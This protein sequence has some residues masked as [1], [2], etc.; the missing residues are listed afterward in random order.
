[1]E[2]PNGSTADDDGRLGKHTAGRKPTHVASS[3]GGLDG[4]QAAALVHILQ[5]GAFSLVG[6]RLSGHVRF[7]DVVSERQ[8]SSGARQRGTH[9][10]TH[11]NAGEAPGGEAAPHHC[12]AAGALAQTNPRKITLFLRAGS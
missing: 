7:K 4:C 3:L 1:M 10:G 9:T 8:D 5:L 11:R 2:R 6:L 12:K